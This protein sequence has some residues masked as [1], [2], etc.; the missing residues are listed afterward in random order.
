MA[1][2][3]AFPAVAAAS[4]SRASARLAAACACRSPASRCFIRARWAWTFAFLA[5]QETEIVPEK[6]GHHG[7][8]GPLGFREC[9]PVQPDCGGTLPFT[10]GTLGRPRGPLPP[11][12]EHPTQQIGATPMSLFNRKP[13]QEPGP[14][15]PPPPRTLSA[16]DLAA[17]S[18][19]MDRWDA[20]MGTSGAMWDCIE[21][22]ARQG[23][24]HGMEASLHESY[25]TGDAYEVT[26]RP[27]R[28]WAAAAR[29]ASATGEHALAGRIFLFTTHYTNLILPK[30]DATY[31]AEIGLSYPD[32]GT[33]QDIAQSAVNSLSQLPPDMLILD[34]SADQLA[35]SPALN[36]ARL[37]ASS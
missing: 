26:R 16:A 37:I 8:P 36:A 25:E 32:G 6:S 21:A 14:A 22:F 12:H 30:M 18:R 23:G 17:A 34:T 11:L 29:L 10:R 20:A 33:F 27:W 1:A 13:R 9:L 19:L 15:A 28:W 2:A 31:Q 5:K 24:F 4:R 35:V 7:F 3:R